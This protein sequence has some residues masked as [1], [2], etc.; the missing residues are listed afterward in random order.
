M[1]TSLVEQLLLGHS[2]FKREYFRSE[3]DLFASLAGGVHEPK[4]LVISCCDA[5]VVPDVILQADPGDLF[6]V[7]NIA[8]LVPPYGKGHHRAVGAAIEYAIMGLKV[9]HVI[10]CGHTMC[11]GLKA[12]ADG[13]VKLAAHMPSLAEWLADAESLYTKVRTTMKDASDELLVKHLAYE[14]VPVQLEN[15]LTYPA[16]NW[17]LERGRLE[18]HGWVYD[19]GTGGLKSYQPEN[20]A[21]VELTDDGRPSLMLPSPI[22]T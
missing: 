16:V 2:Q 12:L 20:N 1:S 10:V 7:R 18:L 17:A 11:G 9:Q 5:R 21:F 15:L 22:G 19:L 4:A 3:S 14:S 6:V 13:P 8:A